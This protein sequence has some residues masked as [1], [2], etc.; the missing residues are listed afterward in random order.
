MGFRTVV[1]KN[2]SKLEVSLNY[3]VCR[4]VD[5]EKRIL[6][7]EIATVLIE[8]TQVAVTSSLLSALAEKNINLIICD[9]KHN[10]VSQMLS[11]Y[12]SYDAYHKLLKQLSFSEERKGNIWAAIINRKILNQSRV[13]EISNKED[14]YKKLLEYAS[15]IERGDITNRE[16]HAAKVYFNSLFGNE[17]SRNQERKEN[18]YLDYG[19]SIIL[20]SVS[21][22]I[23]CI[24]YY[25]E[26][27]VHHIG[28][29]NPFNLSCDFVEPL[30]P[31]IDYQ[32]VSNKV[33]DENYKNTFVDILSLNV[34]CDNK[35][36]LLD[37]AIKT[38]VQSLFNALD[39][40]DISKIKWIN[41]E[42]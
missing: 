28:K 34:D 14:S 31:L 32:V 27:G 8:S 6:L 35:N 25:T 12:G 17:F 30:R 1:V 38:Y 41:Y 37:N 15:E 5:G 16:G 23:K 3:L 18:K 11:L 7:D 42:L 24:G 29:T 20:S 39:N 19:Y 33:N 26:L 21:R 36:M 10:P 4:T 2:R 40:N 9:S 22:A 13:L